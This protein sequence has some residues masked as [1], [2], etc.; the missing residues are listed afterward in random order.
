VTARSTTRWPEG[1]AHA[2]TISAACR[3][4][5]GVV[6]RGVCAGQRAALSSSLSP[7]S[8]SL[9]SSLSL[10]LTRLGA[11]GVVDLFRILRACGILHKV[12]VGVLTVRADLPLVAGAVCRAACAPCSDWSRRISP[13][14]CIRAP[15]RCKIFVYLF[16]GSLTV[17][18]VS[19]FTQNL[20]TTMVSNFATPCAPQHGC[21]CPHSIPRLRWRPLLARVLS[22]DAHGSKVGQG[23]ATLQSRTRL[24]GWR[25]SA[26]CQ[27]PCTGLPLRARPGCWRHH[28]G[29]R[30]HLRLAMR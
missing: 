27:S 5:F 11:Y 3:F 16:N 18:S 15:G 12:E 22:R 25:Y 7:R 24:Q 19:R 17:V 2:C 21:S 6:V 8:C 9:S 26:A 13:V 23:C 10:S 28:Q 29:T 20:T 14:L 1:T 4:G 30:Q